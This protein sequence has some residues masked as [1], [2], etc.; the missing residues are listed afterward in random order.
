[1]GC[2]LAVEDDADL[3]QLNARL[4]RRQGYEVHIAFGAAQARALAREKKPD[5]IILDIQLPDGNGLSLCEEFRKDT[6]TAILFLTGMSDTNDKITGLE[7]GGD[8]YLTKPYD[9]N[10]FLTVVR[11]LLRR[12]EQTREKIAEASVIS[13][14][15]LTLRLNERKAFIGGR[16]AEL[17][18][19]EFAILM[20]LVQSEGNELPYD[21]LYEAVW[22]MPMNGNPT[23]LRKQISRIKKKLGEDG[24]QDFAIFNE[25]GVG[26]TFSMV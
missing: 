23:A 22:G 9:I 6:E 24:A 3:A 26:Y 21:H 17:T 10:E 1:M 14:G 5:L 20:I 19:K 25:H 15:A 8:Y 13:K 4:L 12:V 11:N 16:D 18:P 7:T 2:I